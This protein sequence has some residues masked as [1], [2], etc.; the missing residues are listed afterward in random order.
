[1]IYGEYIGFH[2]KYRSLWLQD[3]FKVIQKNIKNLKFDLK[4]YLKINS[5]VQH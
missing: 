3:I 1:M 5:I 2:L 4:V